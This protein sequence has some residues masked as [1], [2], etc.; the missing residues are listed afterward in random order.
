M[1]LGVAWKDFSQVN[2]CFYDKEYT[3]GISFHNGN[4]YIR[5]KLASSYTP[6]V[7][8]DTLTLIANPGTRTLTY[9]LNGKSLGILMTD[10]PKDAWIA[11]TMFSENSKVQIF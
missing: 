1:S 8:G 4:M 9:L 2:G 10:L 7:P 11:L 3:A 6:C 5:G